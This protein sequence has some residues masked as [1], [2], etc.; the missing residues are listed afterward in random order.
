M[1]KNILKAYQEDIR[2]R[3]YGLEPA[4][5]NGWRVKAHEIKEGKIYKDDNV[6]VEAFLVEHGSWPNAY[7]F[8]FTTPDKIIVISGDTKPCKNIIKYSKG[9][10]IL[11]HEIYYK[12]GFNKRNDCWRK[13]HST[14]HTSTYELAEIAKE[15][16]PGL[17][18]LY[19]ILFF[20][21]TEE[22]IL[23]EIKE[24]YGGN[25]LVGKDLSIY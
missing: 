4:N 8:R 10:D 5:N 24:I 23:N 13:Y 1:T 17:I 20:G 19:H 7:G 22:D 11:I 3:L 9:A 15:T 18:I 2:Y 25:V 14:H 21:G 6:E 16:K 12:K